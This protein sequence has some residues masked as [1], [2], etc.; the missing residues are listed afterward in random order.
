MIQPADTG[1]AET[2]WGRLKKWF[3]PI[4]GII[5]VLWSLDLL[6]RKLQKEVATDPAVRR[7]LDEGGFLSDLKVIALAIAGRLGEIPLS[8]Y[9]LA[10]AATLVAY[11]ALAWYDRIALIHLRR[12]KG[13][14]W[15]YIAVCSFVTYAL[16]HNIGASVLSGGMVRLRAY[17]AK[18]LTAGE[19]AI[20]V[21]I[22]TYTFVY[23]TLML[24]GFVLAFEPQIV[25]PLG[26]LIPLLALP[27]AAVRMIGF[28]LIG[29]CIF[30]VVGSWLHLPPL[31][32]GKLEILYPRLHV[33]G[34]QVIA[35]PLELIGAAGI[36]YFALPAE[37]NPGYFIVLGAFLISFSAGLLSQVPGGVGVMEAVFLAVMPS[38][39]PTAVVAAL[40]IWRLLYLLLPLALS[41]PVILYFEKQQLGRAG[42]WS[43]QRD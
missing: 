14:S 42:A 7:L 26:Q 34:R 16:G 23:G 43:R 6:Y 30:Y 41:V 17:T 3:W 20:L 5:A 29:A 32:I 10:G 11:G 35:A 19:V 38:M 39:A 33:V 13:I 24:L 31:R 1:Q 2:R 21:L 40:L 37:G 28:A 4:L 15:G 25:A 8:G 18:G 22:C 27:E 9:L 36:V 12:E